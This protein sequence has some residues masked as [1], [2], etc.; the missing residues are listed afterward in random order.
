MYLSRSLKKLIILSFVI[1]LGMFW[2]PTPYVVIEPGSAELVKPMVQ[3]EGGFEKEEGSLLLTTVRMTYAN[4]A[5]FVR[6][7]LSKYSDLRLK[8]EV[9]QG[10]TP[11]EYTERQEFNMITSQSGAIQ[12]AYAHAGIPYEITTTEVRVIGTLEDMPAVGILE[13]GD[14]IIKIDQVEIKDREDMVA[15]LSEKF[16]GEAVAVTYIRHGVENTV[17][18]PTA[19]STVDSAQPAIGVY[20][21]NVQTIQADREE[22]QV[23]IEAGAIGGPSAGL[24]FA[25]EIYNRLV[26]DDI[27]KGYTIAGTG[28]IY[29]DGR[30][31][32][33]G[34]VQYKVIAADRVGADIFFVPSRNAQLAEETARA[35]KTDMQIVVVETLEDAL[36]YL[37]NLPLK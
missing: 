17:Q 18:I 7:S 24:M 15:R 6:A 31:G 22:M 5:Y 9:L 27:T 29:P 33:I 34:G 2:M 16:V 23:R 14:Q 30:V 11:R 26:A 13:S 10:E 25:L 12:A 20:I 37:S 28:G 19:G 1:I 35:L 32:V 4:A 36:S 3:I 21:A 8:S